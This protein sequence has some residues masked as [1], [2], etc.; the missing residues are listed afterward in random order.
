MSRWT[1][2]E[3]VDALEDGDAVELDRDDGDGSVVGGSDP[4]SS[5]ARSKVS[6]VSKASA[7]R[8]VFSWIVSSFSRSASR[9]T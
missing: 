2:S 7:G 8:S 3:L 4:V 5:F 6:G 1:S 9:A